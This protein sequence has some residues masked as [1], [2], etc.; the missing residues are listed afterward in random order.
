ME[1]IMRS[2]EDFFFAGHEDGT[3]HQCN[4]SDIHCTACSGTGFFEDQ[5]QIELGTEFEVIWEVQYGDTI[6]RVA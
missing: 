2:F 3:C 5:R 4:G 1:F 6:A